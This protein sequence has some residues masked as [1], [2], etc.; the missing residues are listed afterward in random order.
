[1][2]SILSAFGRVTRWGVSAQMND[3]ERRRV[4]IGNGM[5]LT[6]ASVTFPYAALFWFLGAK[7]LGLLVL[8][9]AGSYL[10][11]PWMSRR[12]LLGAVRVQMVTMFNVAI[13]IFAGSMGA[14]TGIQLLFFVTICLPLVFAGLD[15]KRYLAYGLSLP[16]LMFAVLE[17]T[18]Y[19]ILPATVLP[20]AAQRMVYLALVPTTFTFLLT[21]LLYLYVFNERAEESL[22]HA[23]EE[24]W[25]EMNLA[26]KLQT[27]LLPAAP[28]LRGYRVAAHMI[29]ANEVGGDYYDV[30]HTE[31]R[32]WIAIGD[33]SGH[34]VQS[35]LGMMM[36]QT[37]IQA[38]LFNEREN[39]TC[40]P[41]S[42]ISR[43]NGALYGNFKALSGNMYMTLTL[44]SLDGDTVRYAGMH[45]DILVYRHSS[46]QVVSLET[47]GMWLGIQ[48]DV[49]GMLVDE[50]FKLAE[51]DKMLL[52][53][54]GLTEARK[55]GKMLDLQGLKDLFKDLS[56]AAKTPQQMVDEIMQTMRAYKTQD[57]FTA[58]V[59]ERTQHATS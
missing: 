4:M 53:T 15:N 1:M 2:R 18:H 32:D 23:L 42:I 41:A 21:A 39:P 26:H 14:E 31:G 52:Y 58:V 47:H 33:V 20:P 19:H 6:L 45:Q 17:A 3:R 29:P 43:V 7:M 49:S 12:G 51:G 30:I 5:A 55:D 37:A 24:V 9:I 13:F 57:D 10:F 25:G 35:G 44:L 56:L 38:T 46:R 34:G 48:R 36:C 59:V 11:V 8:P 16:V 28:S 22:G 40:G 27:V 54:D 50:E